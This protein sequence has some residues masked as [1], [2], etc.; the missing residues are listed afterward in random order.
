[1]EEQSIDIRT[2]KAVDSSE[3]WEIRE[4]LLEVGWES[5]KLYSADYWFMTHDYKKVGIERKS[6]ADL[7]S[8]LGTRISDQLFKMVEHFD[9]NILLIEGSWRMMGDKMM[10]PRG[11]EQWGWSTVWNFL[12]SWQDKGVT[13][14][15]TTSEG[16]TIRRLNE[17]YAY[18][19]RPSHTGGLN[20]RTVGDSRLLAFQSGGIGPKLGQAILGKFG[21]L[22][23]AANAS[24]ED[25]LTIEK[26]G[27][28]KAEALYN[29][30]NR[31][32]T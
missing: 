12:Q 31:G 1:M 16:H 29:Y 24:I 7:L 14:Q 27:Q 21:T 11:I 9:F 20:R 13:L 15:L 2:R 28:K 5:R 26:I 4:K 18:Y 25:F 22:R 30:F 3:P 23:I 32:A 6:V 8:S 10:S 19:Q 17:L